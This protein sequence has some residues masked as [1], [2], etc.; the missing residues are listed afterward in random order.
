MDKLRKNSA[1][2]VNKE[3]KKYLFLIDRVKSVVH[4]KYVRPIIVTAFTLDEAEAMIKDKY[5]DLY[6]G[7]FVDIEKI[8]EDMYICW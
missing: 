5:D 6:H 1:H 4:G 3:K 2:R 7:V 8:K